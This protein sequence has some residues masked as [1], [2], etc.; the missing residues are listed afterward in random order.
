MEKIIFTVSYGLII[1]GS[2]GMIAFALMFP[3]ATNIPDYKYAKKR[4]FKISINGQQVWLFS[5]G[6]ILLG[7]GLQILA[8]WWQC[9]AR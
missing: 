3:H 7:T 8:T 1:L 6:A 4:Y 2:C 5:W 9:I